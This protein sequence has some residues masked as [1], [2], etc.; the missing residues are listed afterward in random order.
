MHT[1]ALILSRTVLVALGF[2]EICM[3][4]R[5]ILSFFLDPENPFLTF[6]IAVTEPVILPFRV[7]LSRFESIER[8]SF[9]IPFLVTYFALLLLGRA[10]PTVV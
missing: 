8:L 7:I 10:L 3:F 1:V 2:I 4:L 6:C 5:A 9:D